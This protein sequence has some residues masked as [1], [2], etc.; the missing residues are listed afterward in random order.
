MKN[1]SS[2][3]I[4]D[5][6]FHVFTCILNAELVPA[7]TPVHFASESV[8][9]LVVV[10]IHGAIGRGSCCAESGVYAV[11]IILSYVLRVG[12]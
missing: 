11:L 8:V 9:G 10:G 1:V 4:F 12:S 2:F 7:R 3:F 6:V 5:N